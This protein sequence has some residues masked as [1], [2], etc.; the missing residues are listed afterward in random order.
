M[1]YSEEAKLEEIYNGGYDQ[2]YGH[3]KHCGYDEQ[4]CAIDCDEHRDENSNHYSAYS[5]YL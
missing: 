3:I 4:E 1:T 5:A 2:Q